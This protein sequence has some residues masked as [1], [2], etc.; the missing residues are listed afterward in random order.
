[1][2][3]TFGAVL[4]SIG[5]NILAL[6]CSGEE[7]Q[8]VV[9]RKVF[10]AG[11]DEVGYFVRA[12][13]VA[14]RD[15]VFAE[16]SIQ[17]LGDYLAAEQHATVIYDVLGTKRNVAR[18]EWR[19]KD[20][21]STLRAFG[22]VAGLEVVVPEEGFWVIGAKGA[23][24]IGG[25]AVLTYP[26]DSSQQDRMSPA[27]TVVFEKELVRQLP[28]RSNPYQVDDGMGMQR[29]DVGYY[30]VPEEPNTIIVS[31]YG[32]HDPYHC[33]TT[34]ALLKVKVAGSGSTVA[35]HC[36]W[37]ASGDSIAGPLLFGIVEDFDGDGIR[38]YVVEGLRAGC[39]KD[40]LISGRDGRI[41]AELEKGGSLVVE[42]KEAGPKRIAANAG[43]VNAVAFEYSVEDGAYVPVGQHVELQAQTHAA[44][45]DGAKERV[46]PWLAALGGT[47]SRVRTYAFPD[48]N[49]STCYGL[50][51]SGFD[52]VCVP[53]A[54]WAPEK[55]F[56]PERESVA[57]HFPYVYKSPAYLVEEKK[58]AEVS[59]E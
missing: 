37:W 17:E 14:G 54:N 18:G 48:S 6:W 7:C 25:I 36:L 1:M 27:E 2:R 26:I 16:N 28:V 34:Y 42:R 59:R 3:A 32:A 58:R 35:F 5:M 11:H 46:S 21:L 10:E 47:M 44:G 50:R 55:F 45:P 52:V 23:L 15:Y 49:P 51:A 31:F 8:Q 22:S 41:L 12:L 4:V 38:D 9:S 43:S 33:G 40:V 29:L 30:W 20:P 13:P 57:A 24:A 39:Q 56:R 19:G 53:R